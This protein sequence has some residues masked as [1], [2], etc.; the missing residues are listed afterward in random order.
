MN[1]SCEREGH[2]GGVLLRALEPVAGLEQMAR[3]RGL[4]PRATVKEFDQWPGTAV[5]G[6]GLYAESGQR[7]DLIDPDSPLQ[8]RD[9]GA[10]VG[11]VLVSARIGI[12]HAAELPLRFALAENDCVW[13]PKSQPAR[14]NGCSGPRE[15]PGRLKRYINPVV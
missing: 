9:D 10:R 5:P 2:G 13:G 4:A 14:K 1:V 8:L 11:R 15:P 3:N 7:L 6:A 12:R